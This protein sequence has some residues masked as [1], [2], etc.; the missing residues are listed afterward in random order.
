MVQALGP[1]RPLILLIPIRRQRL[2]LQILV[3][4]DWLQPLQNN[5][6]LVHL[7]AVMALG[8]RRILRVHG[9]RIFNQI[10]E[11]QL[12]HSVKIDVCRHLF[13]QDMLHLE[14]PTIHITID[15]SF[16]CLHP[17]IVAFG[18]FLGGVRLAEFFARV[19]RAV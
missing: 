8:C 19:A 6:R 9:T 18:V 10:R 4:V 11:I 15:V 5:L 7:P 14:R 12:R 13:R 2:L 16:P 17:R 1:A 3:E